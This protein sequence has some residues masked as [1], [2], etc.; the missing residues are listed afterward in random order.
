MGDFVVDSVDGR[1]LWAFHG[2]DRSGKLLALEIDAAGRGVSV[3]LDRRAGL[4]FAAHVLE[5]F[6]VTPLEL[7]DLVQT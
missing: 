5:F 7:D 3:T 1:Q 2:G 4:A 6:D